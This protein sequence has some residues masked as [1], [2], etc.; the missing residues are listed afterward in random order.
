[1][2]RNVY[3]L[4]LV[5]NGSLRDFAR[6]WN[7]QQSATANMLWGEFDTLDEVRERYRELAYENYN[8]ECGPCE[9]A[10]DPEAECEKYVADRVESLNIEWHD[11]LKWV[12]VREM[13]EDDDGNRELVKVL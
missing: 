4:W 3:E 10:D 12:R 8:R 13:V 1:M 9:Y 11:D 7:L 5:D 2:K 6:G